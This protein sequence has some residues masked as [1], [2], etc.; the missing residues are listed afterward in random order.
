MLAR[1][2]QPLVRAR[3]QEVAAEGAPAGRR[4]RRRS[5]APRRRRTG[6]ATGGS[7]PA[8]PSRRR[9]L[10]PAPGRL[11]WVHPRHG[12]QLRRRVMPSITRPTMSSIVAALGVVVQ[13]GPVIRAPARAASSREALLGGVE[14]IGSWSGSRAGGAGEPT[15]PVLSAARSGARGRPCADVRPAARPTGLSSRPH[16]R[17][18]AAPVR[19]RA[20]APRGSRR[21]PRRGPG[22]AGTARTPPN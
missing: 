20:P 4:R 15:G 11:C 10:A 14:V 9:S 1:P 18:R 13:V 19:C 12:H 7:L 17:R 16:P 3:G 8:G 5:R 6:T 22:C 21:S 2:E